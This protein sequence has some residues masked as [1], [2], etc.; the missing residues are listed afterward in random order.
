MTAL[1]IGLTV[2][3]LVVMMALVNGLDS[4]F[5]ET[6]DENTLVIIRKGSQ[7]EV[8]SYFNR[9]L[10]KTVR[11][12][13]GVAR[14]SED[15][16]LAVGEILVVINH[17]KLEG[18]AS[19]L[20]FRGTSDL[21]F[22]MRSEVA[23]IEG[24]RF[25]QGVREI[26][27]SQSVSNRFDGMRIGDSLTIAQK[28]WQVVGVFDASGSAYSSEIWG[29]YEDIAMAWTR[30]I[31]NSILVKTEGPEATENLIEKVDADRRIQ[32]QAIRQTEYFAQQT[33]S[34]MGVKA[35]GFFIAIF[36]GVGSCFAAMNMMYGTILARF[37]EIGT[38]RALGF[39]RRSILASFLLE[40]VLLAIIGG[41]IG[42]IIALPAHG[43]STGTTNFASFSEVLFNFRIT[44]GILGKAV[45]FAGFVGVVGGFLPALRAARLK[46]VDVL[47]D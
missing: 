44:P 11:L 43:I 7:N 29:S 13:E 35:L 27:V 47:R 2:A 36:M 42:C 34:S 28:D 41:I 46:L 8:N 40:S 9:E 39:K 5:V 14:N 4:T 33:V 17:D 3:V 10:Y 23:L 22:E 37:K 30:P 15:E 31:Y 16:P 20:S 38:L 21:G 32:L 19:N 1:G 12:M 45:L 18:G 26:V 6:G 24:R 25:R